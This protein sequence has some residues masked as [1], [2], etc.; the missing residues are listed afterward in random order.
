[1]G[2]TDKL[3]DMADNV[4]DKV[5]GPER[6]KEHIGKG[7]DAVDKTTGRRY[8]EQ[9]DKA[10]S[11]AKSAVD[12]LGKKKKQQD[13]QQQQRQERDQRQERPRHQQPPS[14]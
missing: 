1:M 8:E 4:M 6:A 2:I 12:K 3:G 5:G 11:G 9:V 14:R 13:Q 7:A 10:E